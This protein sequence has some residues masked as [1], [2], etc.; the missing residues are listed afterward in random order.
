MAVYIPLSGR[1]LLLSCVCGILKKEKGVLK[2]EYAER[3]LPQPGL[4][5]GI[6]PSRQYRI[7]VIFSTCTSAF[8]KFLRLLHQ[9]VLCMAAASPLIL[10]NSR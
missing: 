3:N 8:N 10:V 7:F 5:P 1:V 4:L 9:P 6:R 2:S